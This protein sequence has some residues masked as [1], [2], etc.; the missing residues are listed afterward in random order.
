MNLT[1]RWLLPPWWAPYAFEVLLLLAVV[2]GLRRRPFAA[3]LP[4]AAGGW[5]IAALFVVIGGVTANRAVYALAGRAPPSGK[6]V[7][8]VFR[9]SDL[10][11]NAHLMALDDAV[12]RF[13]AWRGQSYGVDIM[14]IIA[15]E[16][17]AQG[18]QPSEPNAYRIYD[19]EVLALCARPSP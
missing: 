10:S 11:V 1:G 12:P 7:D 8:L 4:T 2:I 15:L 16:L 5:L 18:V 19:A 14:Q 17:R 6:V 13:R 3:L 9:C